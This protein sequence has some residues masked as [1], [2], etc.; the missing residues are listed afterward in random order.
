MKYVVVGTSHAG[1]AVIETLLISDP[2]AEIEVFESAEAPSF[3]S[4]GIQSYLEDVAPSLQ[5]LHYADAESLKEQGVNLHLQTTV[6]DLNTQNKTVTI[7]KDGHTSKVSYDKLFLSPGAVPNELP[8]NGINDYNN[9]LFMRGEDWAGKI[10][11]RMQN[12]KKAI[13]VGGGYIGIEAAEAFT[14]AGIDTTLMDDHDRIIN[15]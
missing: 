4:C 5:S 7:R 10:K 3:L 14:K 6:T 1:Y 15:T 13:V 9:V 2:E 8:I 12:A 11:E